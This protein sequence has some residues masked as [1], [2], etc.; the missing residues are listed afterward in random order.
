MPIHVNPV[1]KSAKLTEIGLPLAVIRIGDRR[2]VRWAQK[3]RN[4]LKNRRL[5]HIAAAKN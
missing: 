3:E 1:D 2:R 4:G 5:P